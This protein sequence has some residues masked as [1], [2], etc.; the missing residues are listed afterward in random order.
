MKKPVRILQTLLG[1]FALIVLILDSKTAI[2][3]GIEGIHICLQVLIP[4]LFPFLFLCSWLNGK[5][6]QFSLPFLRPIQKIFGMSS[7]GEAVLLT[8][9]LSGYPIGAQNVCQLWN[10]GALD[11][12]DARRLLGYCS[13]AGPSFI[14][15][16]LGPIFPSLRITFLLWLTQILSALL[17]SFLLP[18]R[19]IHGKLQQNTQPITMTNALAHATKGMCKI[20]GWAI[21]FRVLIAV[22]ERWVL[23]M[24][25]DHVKV[26]FTGLLELSN[27][28]LGLSV[29]KSVGVRFVYASILLSFGGLCVYMQTSSVTKDLGTGMYL[30]G[31][32]LQCLIATTISILLLP[33]VETNVQ[34]VF[35]PFLIITILLTAIGVAILYRNKI[36]LAFSGK[37]LYNQ[38]IR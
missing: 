34:I 4:S 12:V 3:G 8:T 17:V 7:G 29:I 37:R 6:T 38:S 16:V 18:G 32:I 15:G 20:C 21:L 10:N 35:L 26:L 2:A 1:L 23:W 11:T 36:V 9:F 13:I 19:A 33:V 31:K 27:G 22:L 28:C 24:M 14:F 5:L 25:Y 30:P